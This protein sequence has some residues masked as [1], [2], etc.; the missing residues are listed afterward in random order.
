MSDT[1]TGKNEFKK[2]HIL[3]NIR[4]YLPILFATCLIIKVTGQIEDPSNR[5]GD[6]YKKYSGATCPLQP[7]SIRHFVYFAR[8]RELIHNHPFLS[9]HR[10]TGAQIMYPWGLLEPQKGEYDFSIIRED[11]NY[12][13]SYGKKLFIQLQDATF[14][15]G[16][17]G[18]PEYLLTAEFDGG[19]VPEFDD[20]GKIAGWVAKRWNPK[21]QE[22]FALL[23]TRLGE[24][25]DGKAEGINF[26]ESAIGDKSKIDT[27]FTP[28]KYIESLKINMLVLKKAFPESIKMQ[29]AN[30]I[31]GEWLPGDDKGYLRSIY[32]YGQEIGVGLGSPDLMVRRKGQLN[33]AL[34]MMHEGKFTVPIGIAVQ[35]GNY[36]EQTG[37]DEIVTD[38]VNIVPLLHAFAKDFLKV[39]YMFWACQEP[40]F[41]DDLIPCFN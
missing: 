4:Q 19:T 3:K 7:D 20:N 15:P 21:V 12:L 11:Y 31:P 32:V 25:F 17:V 14:N 41:S 5:Y 29:Y 8:N 38:R 36:I 34:A 22:R 6:A 33:H 18:L 2:D 28:V 40:Y 16:F 9:I 26:Q 24:E 27:S 35:D 1:R 37:T 10:F 23:L 13:L 39:D 30:F